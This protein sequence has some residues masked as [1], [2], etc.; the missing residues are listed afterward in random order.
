MRRRRI[1]WPFVA[2]GTLLILGLWPLIL[3]SALESATPNILWRAG[4][5][6]KVLALTFDDGPHEVYTPHLLQILA[7]QEV[8]ATFFLV[9]E[10]ARRFP[11]L[12]EAIRAAGH[13]IANHSD[14]L[15][16]TVGLADTAFVANLLRAEET[17]HLSGAEPKFFRPAG[18]FIWPSQAAAARA[19][20]YTVTLA[21]GYAFDP[22]RP[23][24]GYMVWQ[25]KR[26]LYPG[27]IWVLHDSG[28]DRSMTLRAVEI[29]IPW[30]K[31]QGYRFVALTELA[32]LSG[33]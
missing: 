32:K 16:R 2:A 29:L 6:Q 23:P 26:S 9:G 13:E 7:G 19:Q 14:S 24:V 17:L 25:M 10:R 1:L 11:A 33:G 18:G 21:S 3:I 15:D 27:A 5:Q 22:Y 8:T 31:R 12:V 20:G 28:G 30:A 4:T